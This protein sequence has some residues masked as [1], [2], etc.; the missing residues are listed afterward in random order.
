MRSGRKAGTTCNASSPVEASLTEYPCASSEARRKP[1]DTGFVVNDQYPQSWTTHVFSPMAGIRLSPFLLLYAASRGCGHCGLPRI[2]CRSKGQGLS[3]SALLGR[4]PGKIYRTRVRVPLLESPFHDREPE[5]PV[6]QQPGGPGFPL[7]ASAGE[8]FSA[9]S[10]KFTSTCTI[11]TSSIGTRGR[12][13]AMVTKIAW[14]RTDSPSWRSAARDHVV[15]I[16][17]LGFHSYRPA[18]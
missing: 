1:T 3:L 14:L 10:S 8:Y 15:H 18:F 12:P 5:F 13:G 17:R 16:A 9:L 6:G 7:G 2:P 4:Q 11:R